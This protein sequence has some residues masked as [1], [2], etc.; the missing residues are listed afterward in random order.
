MR[1]DTLLKRHPKNP[2]IGPKDF[3]YGYA[4]QI[5]NPGQC[6]FR[7]KV[8][9]LISVKLADAPYT[10]AHVATSDD[11]I[12]FEIEKDPLFFVDKN[13]KFGELDMHPIDFRI[14]QM[15]DTYYIMRPGNSEWG[16]VAFLYKTTDFKTV[17][18]VEI[19]ALPHNR[20]PCL[21][22]EK[23]NGEYVRLDRPYSVGA[24][25]EKSYA[26]MWI[27]RSPDL[28]HWGRHRPLLSR[29]AFPWAG[30]KV[31]PTVP[32][33]TERGWLEIIHGV[34]N[35]FMGFRYSLGA[36]M[37]D[38]NE[39]EKITGMIKRYILTPETEYEHLGVIP[40]V[41]FATGAIA[42]LKARKLR[43]YYGGADTCL[44]LAE[45]D[46]DEIIDECLNEKTK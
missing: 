17:E 32:I 28:I 12:N 7:G 10:Q 37:L 40:D 36:I 4:D 29:N 18:P 42:D 16:C 5:F 44:C 45:G 46:L 9:L 39:P 6:M 15:G 13:K 31:G 8:L 14:T 20:V 30:L 38:L 43:V 21:F 23:I 25:Y 27:S 22:P 2:I 1:Y 3:P 41:V 35:T 11:G 34:Q 24:P 19:I 26:N 33:K